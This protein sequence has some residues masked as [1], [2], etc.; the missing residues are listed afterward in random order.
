[1][2]LLFIPIVWFLFGII[3]GMIGA[4]KGRGGC[5]WFVLGFLLGPFGL[6]VALL[7]ATANP[8][9]TRKCPFCGEIVKHE[10]S[11]CRFCHK[12]LPPAEIPRSSIWKRHI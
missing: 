5:T 8:G 3:A 4:S 10:A 1:M 7:P 6:L 9:V 12:D 11:I 2:G